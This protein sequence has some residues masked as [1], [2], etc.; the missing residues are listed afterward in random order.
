M[1]PR[2][3]NQI[4]LQCRFPLQQLLTWM[5]DQENKVALSHLLLYYHHQD[6]QNLREI[7]HSVLTIIK[8]SH[9]PAPV[10]CTTYTFMPLASP[11]ECLSLIHRELLLLGV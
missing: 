8:N 7:F 1:P 3:K 6:L 4:Q 2:G 9:L 11:T 10:G 5:F